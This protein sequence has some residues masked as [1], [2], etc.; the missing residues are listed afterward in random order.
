[1]QQLTNLHPRHI[2]TGYDDQSA[3]AP[4]AGSQSLPIHLPLFFTFAESGKFTPQLTAGAP[5]L[6]HYGDATFNLKSKFTNHSSPFITGCSAAGNLMQ[7]HR[8][9]SPGIKLAS[10]RWSLD[11]LKTVLPIYERDTFGNYLLDDQGDLIETGQTTPAYIG[12]Y[13][14]TEVTGDVGSAKPGPGSMSENG[15]QSILYP[16]GEVPAESWGS[17]GNKYGLR[18]SA[19]NNYS[20]T[21]PDIDLIERQKTRLFRME[22]VKRADERSVPKTHKTLFEDKYVEFSFNPDSYDDRF[23]SELFVDKKL[24]KQYRDL[25]DRTSGF[26]AYGPFADIKFYH[27]NIATICAA[28]QENESAFGTMPSD[29]EYKYLVDFFNGHDLEGSP[30][31]SFR[32]HGS[33]DNAPELTDIS[34]HY[35]FGGDDGDTSREAFNAAVKEQLD[36]FGDLEAQYLDNA[37]YP[38]SCFYDTGFDLETKKS[39]SKLLGKRQDIHLAVATQDI[40]DAQYTLSQ[41][42]SLAISLRAVL[43][44]I[45][46]SI[47]FGTSTCRAVLMAQ[48]GYIIGSPYS[49]LVPMTYELC[50]KRAAY[51]GAST[52]TMKTTAAYDIDPL[53]HVEYLR[54]VNNT[55]APENVRNKDWDAGLVSARWYDHERL[56][57]PTVQTIYDDQSSILNS[58][59]NMQ[60]TVELSKVS[61]RVWRELVGNS[62]LKRTEFI[63]ASD[64]KIIEKTT[65]RFDG[66]GVVIPETYHSPADT[67]NGAS[68]S[69]RIHWY[70]TNN[71]QVAQSTIVTHRLE[72]LQS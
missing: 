62:R 5:M 57:I 43:R 72:D 23:D 6:D 18:L 41:E 51:M 22:V 1:M 64:Q 56:H 11:L 9:P 60:I 59:M 36:N 54:D 25:E 48:S 55:W 31:H 7:I 2:L 61:F 52:G 37:R 17:G 46:E 13:V 70:G 35:L 30:Y 66:R 40:A 29:P 47:L 8:L 24:L 19:P 65:D 14:L 67:A 53:N 28:I 4:L 21:P 58:D 3:R 71:P 16:I 69:A 49:E 10:L 39:I 42:S 27:D 44:N 34:T 38:F 26:P 12:K 32:L 33:M 63:E 68:W 20:Q 50:M 15:V 45:P